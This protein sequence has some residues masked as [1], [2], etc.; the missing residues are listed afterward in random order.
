[1][2]DCVAERIWRMAFSGKE[3]MRRFAEGGKLADDELLDLPLRYCGLVYE[4]G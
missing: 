4:G 2:P 3:D 1:M